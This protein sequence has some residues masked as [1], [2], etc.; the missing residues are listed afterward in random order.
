VDL[1]RLLRLLPGQP[2]ELRWPWLAALLAALLVGLVVWWA[3]ERAARQP[4]PV[5]DTERLRRLPRFRTLVRR[6]RALAALHSLGALTAVA[7]C[8]LLAARPASVSAAPADQPSLDLV[9]CLDVSPSMLPLDA[10]V[11]KAVR[12]VVDS[13]PGDRIGLSI[14]NGPSVTKSPLTFDRTFVDHLLD[15]AQTAFEDRDR[16]FYKATDGYRTSLVAEG[17]IGCLDRFDR[18]DEERGRVVLVVSDNHPYGRRVQTLDDAARLARR[19]G[20]V[21][22]ALA[23]ARLERRAE[24]LAEFR[25]AAEQ[26][27]GSL[28]VLE[29]PS[30]VDQVVSRIDTLER[31]RLVE[32][33]REVTRDQPQGG[34]ALAACGLG[35]LAVVW[36]RR[37]A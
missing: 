21:V 15:Q 18:L 6:R 24:P 8:L 22:H 37:R 2:T 35:L 19:L 27:G 36:S 14:F 4:I 30:A 31:R 23:P 7:G 26:T 5:S 13:L 32:P 34:L 17:L 10:D 20:V 1:S 11:V 16:A 33:S 12:D 28:S 3:S 29:D 25:T 9:V